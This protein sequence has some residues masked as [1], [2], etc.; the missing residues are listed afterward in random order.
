MVSLITHDPH[1]GCRHRSEIEERRSQ[2]KTCIS[3]LR[4]QGSKS[5][6]KL[7]VLV[8]Q[9]RSL[10]TAVKTFLC[11]PLTTPR[12]VEVFRLSPI[13]PGVDLLLIRRLM[14]RRKGPRLKR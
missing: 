8:T 3:R 7:E 6:R 2:C 13:G 12:D 1:P 10:M 11:G 5:H 14:S 4:I 9:Q